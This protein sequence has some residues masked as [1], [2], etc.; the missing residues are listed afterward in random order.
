M[1]EETKGAIAFWSV[2]LFGFGFYIFVGT[3]LLPFIRKT[4]PLFAEYF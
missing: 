1:K 4:N 2:M 3:V